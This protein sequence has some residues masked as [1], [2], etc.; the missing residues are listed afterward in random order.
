MSIKARNRKAD[1]TSGTDVTVRADN[2]R[3]RGLKRR[4][5]RRGH[6]RLCRG[7]KARL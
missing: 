7:R 1:V 4:P 2:V 3:D 5:Q 6:R